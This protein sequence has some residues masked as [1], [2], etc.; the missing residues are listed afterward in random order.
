MERLLGKFFR[1]TP[2]QKQ[3]HGNVFK[4]TFELAL[5]ERDAA[6]AAFGGDSGEDVN[7]DQIQDL[8]DRDS[9]LAIQQK[10]IDGDWKIGKIGH[11][12]ASDLGV[13]NHL[14][15]MQ[16]EL[17]HIMRMSNLNTKQARLEARKFL[18]EKREDLLDGETATEPETLH[19][20]AAC[21][22]GI[23]LLRPYSDQQT[24]PQQSS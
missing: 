19:R 14:N 2:E 20:I 12:I 11:G 18:L 3:V 9:F 23:K 24:S 8:I 6:W 21:T 10:I 1:R 5:Q 4:D 7:I 13:L 16:Y 22:A 15:R 17:D